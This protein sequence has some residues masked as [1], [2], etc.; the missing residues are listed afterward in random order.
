MVAVD[1]P[2]TFAAARVAL[3]NPQKRQRAKKSGNI[4]A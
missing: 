1:R 4:P 3:L 2:S